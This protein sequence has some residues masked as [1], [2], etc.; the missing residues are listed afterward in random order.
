MK[1]PSFPGF[2]LVKLPC[3]GLL[4]CFMT[5][6][7]PAVWAAQEAMVISEEAVIYSDEKMSSPL[8]YVRKGKKVKVG[9]IPRNKAQVYPI[10]VSGRKAFI[11]SADIDTQADTADGSRLVSERF[12]KQARKDHLK[13]GVTLSYVSFD[14]QI[15][16]VKNGN[17]LQSNDPLAWSG[18]SLKGEALVTDKV[19]LQFISN[20]LQGDDGN[21]QF[22]IIE[23]GFGG[24]YRVLDLDRWVVRLEFQG[25]AIPF[26]SYSFGRFFRV[27]GHGGTI[28]GGIS[29]ALRLGQHL[30]IEVFGGPYLTQLSGLD[31][32]APA[33]KIAP[34]F[35]GTR[36]GAGINYRY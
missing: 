24:A 27:I 11:R 20:F 18:I 35:F 21:E 30:G 14:S 2:S 23:L 17:R 19:E 36:L 12:F 1:K 32:P 9:D 29:T 31:V 33:R 7:C 34:T 10:I 15:G 6:L 5:A 26:S 3:L 22:R 28:G 8:G 13:A 16:S 4:S 25:L